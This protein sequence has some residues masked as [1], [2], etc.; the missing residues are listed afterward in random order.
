MLGGE[1]IVNQIWETHTAFSFGTEEFIAR[2]WVVFFSPSHT[3]VKSFYPSLWA[4]LE[5]YL[6]SGMKMY[7]NLGTIFNLITG[8]SIL[9][10]KSNGKVEYLIFLNLLF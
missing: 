5:A 8:I 3:N 1:V 6:S 4:D 10:F 2:P 7:R 9:E